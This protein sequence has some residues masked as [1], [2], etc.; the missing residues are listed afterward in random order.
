MRKL[1]FIVSLL[2][3][4]FLLI[5]INLSSPIQITSEKDILKLEQNQKVSMQGNVIDEK[6]SG[7][8]RT[9]ILNNNITLYCNCPSLP[10]LKNKNITAI[11]FIDTF[12]KTKI[13]ILKIS[14]IKDLN[15]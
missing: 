12:Q 10:R 13:K 2:T 3:L 4:F 1:A 15:L 9:L 11:G 8:S 6:S 7:N 14:I 5:Y